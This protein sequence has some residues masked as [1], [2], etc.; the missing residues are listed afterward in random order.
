MRAVDAT[1]I[2]RKR[3]VDT[4][5]VVRD[6]ACSKV[7]RLGLRQCFLQGKVVL[8]ASTLARARQRIPPEAL[9][10]ALRTFVD[11]HRGVDVPRVFAIDSSKM[12]LPS[13]FER[14]GVLP[15]NAAA[16]RPLAVQ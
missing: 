3:R 13:R 10:S 4:L 14:E 7:R 9:G 16:A 8:H 2:K 1:W 5:Q 12:Q 15:R 11:D 6:I